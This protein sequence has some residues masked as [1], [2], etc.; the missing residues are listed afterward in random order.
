MEITCYWNGKPLARWTIP[1][2]YPGQEVTS[3]DI[4][5]IVRLE[6][7]VTILEEEDEG[8]GSNAHS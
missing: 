3:E 5:R 8:D 7:W 1:Q 2:S 4:D 6:H